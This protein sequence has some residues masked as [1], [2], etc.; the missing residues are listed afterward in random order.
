MDDDLSIGGHQADHMIFAG[1]ETELLQIQGTISDP[2]TPQVI[3]FS[4]IPQIGKT[5]LLQQT[6]LQER[7]A[8]YPDARGMVFNLVQD[9]E[10]M[11][12]NLRQD[13]KLCA[14]EYNDVA[15]EDLLIGLMQEHQ[16]MAWMLRSFLEGEPVHSLDQP[17]VETSS[18][19]GADLP[20]PL[21]AQ[22]SR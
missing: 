4:G 6:R 11:V 15:T 5:T 12:R 3:A 7:P 19:E 2:N 1:R 17:D 22:F 10:A 18:A 16:E 13:A 8:D 20:E 14:D 21:A 9:H